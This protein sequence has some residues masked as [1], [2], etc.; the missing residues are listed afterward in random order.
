MKITEPGIYRDL[1]PA[2]YFADPCPSPSLTQSI[3]KILID[4]S[5]A[6]AR[7]AHP[8]LVPPVAEDAAEEDTA[9]KYDAVKAI[10]NAAHAALIGRGR[11]I[12]EGNFDSW[13]SKDAKTF[14][15][16]ALASGK[17]V[18]L[19]KHLARAQDMIKAASY[20]L[21]AAG[22][23]DAF[24]KGNGEVVLAWREG[25]VWFRTMID[26]LV[27]TTK[28]YD[29]K[30]TG[31]SVAPHVVVD[32]P[33]LE[34][35]DIQAAMHERG[36]DALDPT[37]AG[38]RTFHYINQENEPPYA[39]VPV[40]ISEHDLTMGRKKLDYAIE[41]WR[42]CMEL[43]TWPLYPADT[44]MSRPRAW[45]EARWLERELEHEEHRGREPMLTDL[46]GG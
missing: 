14:K 46:R 26:W 40:R 15:A 24:R 16:E 6:H 42:R 3:A 11:D 19:S 22:H 38:R 23:R 34:G 1:A 36:L 33:S 21:D 45:T 5:P 43:N 32:R 39:L 20:Q 13:R 10:G 12:A 35:W 17:I 9:E 29:Y 27:D 31:L 28:P 4:E 25:D 37:N 44:V 2:D 7:L 8:R 41:I 18:I 30:S